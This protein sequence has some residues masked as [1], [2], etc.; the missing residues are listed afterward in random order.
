MLLLALADLR[1]LFERVL[2]D[3]PPESAPAVWER[4]LDFET[5][6]AASGGSLKAVGKVSMLRFDGGAGRG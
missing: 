2:K 3:M 6:Q 1:L 4:F 5:H